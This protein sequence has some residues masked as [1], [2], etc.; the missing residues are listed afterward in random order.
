LSRGLN[1]S[2]RLLSHEPELCVIKP[3]IEASDGDA[4]GNV[5][6]LSIRAKV[7]PGENAVGREGLGE[8]K[9]TLPIDHIIRSEHVQ[10][11]RE[12]RTR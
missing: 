1:D 4:H 5:W 11:A 12:A 2:Q 3:S 10:I 7:A 6:V 9:P 8:S